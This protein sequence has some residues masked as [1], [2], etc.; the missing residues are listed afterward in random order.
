MNSITRNIIYEKTNTK[1]ENLKKRIDFLK[2]RI[3][4]DLN[5]LVRLKKIERDSKK[6][7]YQA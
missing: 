1:T 7:G 3:D 2:D 5:V 6:K 4:D